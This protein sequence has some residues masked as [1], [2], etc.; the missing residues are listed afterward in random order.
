MYK[1]IILLAFL[2]S[3]TY[4]GAQDLNEIDATVAQYPNRFGSSEELAELINRDFK[5]DTDKARAIFSWISRNV[6]YDI[7][8]HFSKKKKKRI[9]YK[10]K[11]DRAQKERQQRIK[12]ENK[13]LSQH[14]AL[15]KGYATLFKRLCD[16]TGLYAYI[17][18]GTGKLRTYD[19][20]RLPRMRN[21]QWNAV[22]IDKDWFFVD[23][24]M[25]AGTVDYFEKS[26]QPYFNDNYF[27]THPDTFFLNHYPREE[28]W[29]LTEK[30]AE[31]FAELPL[32]YSAC[33]KN[34]YEI[35]TPDKGLLELK[36]KDSI[37]F[38]IKSPT[39]IS[40]LSFKFNYDKEHQEV[41]IESQNGEY[42]FS[43][44]FTKRRTGYLTLYRQ[45]R[46]I[47]SYRIN[48]Y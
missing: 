2:V 16:L 41:K 27:F 47:V 26:Y 45:K 34:E 39:P 36:G 35:I 44:P 43:V 11:V 13:A 8:E 15:A 48:S 17:I 22:Q 46:A 25:G 28:E 42:H 21:H 23:A 33:L 38:R 20:G 40:D 3:Y 19:I 4:L 7:E 10:D 1:L 32:I 30:K 6:K 5:T 14:L 29:L 37:E 9:S 12:L 24:M 31:D 18:E